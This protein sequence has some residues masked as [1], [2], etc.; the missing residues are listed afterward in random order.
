MQPQV[1]PAH[2]AQVA[3]DAAAQ[4][5]GPREIA[6]GR[7]NYNGREYVVVP[8]NEYDALVEQNR[9]LTRLV[10]TLLAQNQRLDEQNRLLAATLQTMSAKQ[11]KLEKDVKNLTG[12]TELLSKVT[13]VAG[14]VAAAAGVAAVASVVGPAAIALL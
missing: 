4:Q 11:E 8:K 3:A 1:P 5:V 6:A 7:V 14:V 10:Q 13:V 2:I 12:K 9:E